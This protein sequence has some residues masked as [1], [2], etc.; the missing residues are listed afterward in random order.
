[1]LAR[2][3]R[4]LSAKDVVGGNERFDAAVFIARGT[5]GSWPISLRLSHGASHAPDCALCSHRATPSDASF[6]KEQS[7]PTQSIMGV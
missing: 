2:D 6:M 5:S 7:S 1:M 4:T 3:V